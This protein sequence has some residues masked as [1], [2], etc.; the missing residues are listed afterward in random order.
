MTDRSRHILTLAVVALLLSGILLSVFVANKRAVDSADRRAIQVLNDSARE[1]TSTLTAALDGCFNALNSISIQLSESGDPFDPSIEKKLMQIDRD[2]ALEFTQIRILDSSGHAVSTD[3]ERASLDFS[4]RDYFKTAMSGKSYMQKAVGKLTGEKT[5]FLSVPVYKGS[6]VGGV[7]IGTFYEKEIRK[8]FSSEAYG[9]SGFSYVVESGGDIVIDSESRTKAHPLDNIFDSFDKQEMLKGY[10]IEQLKRDLKAG[11]STHIEFLSGGVE[12]IASFSPIDSPKLPVNDWFMVNAV[13]KDMLI[14]DVNA[15]RRDTLEAMLIFVVFAF[16]AL[17]LFFFLEREHRKKDSLAA[18]ELKRREEEYRIVAKQ[19]DKKVYRYNIKTE[20]AYRSEKEEDGFIWGT[21]VNDFVESNI[22]GGLVA[23]ESIGPYRDFHASVKAGKSPVTGDFLFKLANGEY[24]WFRLISTTIFDKDGN[25]DTAVVSYFDYTEQREREL[26]YAKWQQELKV[27]SDEDFSL[28]EWNLT[29]GGS[30]GYSGNAEFVSTHREN[31]LPFDAWVARYSNIRVFYDDIDDFNALMTREHLLGIYYNGIYQGSVEYRYV[32]DNASMCWHKMSIQMVPYPETDEIKIY[33]SDR[34]IDEEKNEELDLITRSESDSLTG[35]LNR[36]TFIERVQSVIQNSDDSGHALMML[37]LD[38]FKFVNDAMGHETG[39]EVLIEFVQRIN[40]VLRNDDFVGRVGG[41][42]F[43]VFIHNMPY[44]AAVGKKARDFCDVLRK[45]IGEGISVTVSIGIAMFPKDGNSFEELYNCADAAL[46]QAKG[47]GKDGYAFYE[48]GMTSGSVL[49]AFDSGANTDYSQ[50]RRNEVLLISDSEETIDSVKNALSEEYELHVVK[51]TVGLTE[52][53]GENNKLSITITDCDT[54]L[55]QNTARMMKDYGTEV[56]A[57]TKNY[58]SEALINYIE[59]GVAAVIPLPLNPELLRVSLVRYFMSMESTAERAQREYRRIQNS[60][61]LRYR[62]VLRATGTT[63]FVYD[64]ESKLYQKDQE[65]EQITDAVLDGY[66]LGETLM[67]GGFARE[68]DI[69]TIKDEL[70]NVIDGNVEVATSRLKIKTKSGSKRWFEVLIKKIENVQSLTP[71][72]LILVNDIDEQVKKDEE[73][74]AR[75]ERDELTGLY[76]R[77]TFFEKSAEMIE[78]R[79]PGYYMM[80][81]FDINN[82]KVIND[83]YGTAKGDDVLK[84]LAKVFTE[85]FDPLGGIVCRV[86]ADNFA[87]L[88]PKKYAE[89]SELEEIR[90]KARE[91]DGTIPPITYSIGRYTVTDKSMDVNAMYDRAAMA[92]NSVKGMYDVHTAE[93]DES[94][95]ERIVREQEIVNEMNDALKNGEFEPWIQPQYNHATGALVGGEILVRWNHPVRGVIM[96]LDFVPVFERNGFIYEM[97]KYIW[98]EACRLLRKWIDA[99]GDAMPLAVN[100]SR[101]DILKK[102][103]YETITDI[104]ERNNVP[105]ELFRL[106]I[107]ETAFSESAKEI[108]E[109]VDRLKAYG[110]IIEIDDFGSGYSSLNTL[111]DV[112]ANILK[113]DMRFIESSENTQRGGNI[114][115]SIIRMAKWLGMPVIAEGVETMEQAEFLKSIGCNYVQGYLY[116]RPMPATEYENLSAKIS[117]EHKMQALE[118]VENMDNNTFWDPKSMDTLIF[119]SYVGGACIIEYHRGKSETMRIN[120]KYVEA[121]GAENMSMDDVMKINWFDHA[122]EENKTILFDAITKAIET[123]SEAIFDVKL[124]GLPGNPCDIFLHSTIRVI[125]ST[126][127]RY[128]IYC[129]FDNITEQKETEQ[130]EQMVSAQLKAIMDNINGGVTAVVIEDGAPRYLFA[131]D[132]YFEQLGYTREQ[133][134]DE[135]PLSFDLIYEEDRE[136][137]INTTVKASKDRENYAVT[138]RVIRRDG[139]MGYIQS[140]ISITDFPGIDEPVQL[141]VANDITEQYRAEQAIIESS[142]Q[143]LFLNNISKE[144]LVEGDANT[145]IEFVLKRILDYFGG[146]RAA[147]IE[148]NK[149][150]GRDKNTYEVC[151]E[152]VESVRDELQDIPKEIFYHW[153][154]KL[155]KDKHMYFTTE[156]LGE[157]RKEERKF[158]ERLNITSEVAVPLLRDD[159]IIGFMG[160]ENPR[161]KRTHVDRMEAL[162]D[163]MAVLLTRR[164]LMSKIKRDSEIIRRLMDDTPGG[165]ARVQLKPGTDKYRIVYVNDNLCSML[166]YSRE[167]ML[168]LYGDTGEI[169]IHPDDRDRV[170]GFVQEIDARMGEPDATH[171]IRFRVVCKDGSAKEVILFARGTDAG[172]EGIFYNLYYA[173]ASEGDL[174]IHEMMPTMLSAM[175]ES[176]SELAFVKDTELNYICCTKPFAHMVGLKDEKE[177]AGKT[178]YDIFEKQLAENYIRDDKLVIKSG[179]SLVDIIERIPSEDGKIRYSQTSKHLLFNSLGEVIGLYGAGRDVTALVES[180]RMDKVLDI[181]INTGFEY[182]CVVHTEEGLYEICGNNVRNSH[183]VDKTGNFDKTVEMICREH[184]APEDREEYLQNAKLDAVVRGMKETNGNYSYRYVLDGIVR[185][186]RFYYYEDTHNEMVMTIKPL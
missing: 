31:E 154:S 30:D 68:E 138:Y 12:R 25:P 147:V 52:K 71:K 79:E 90:S 105:P 178:D 21:E 148:T 174:K 17:V 107:T 63:V 70:K 36:D 6:K 77:T 172:A 150:T 137:V 181:A 65:V 119:N 143:L 164:D 133:F 96:P 118:T 169:A 156:N 61:E 144:L 66:A 161:Q 163:Y 2:A 145:A 140:N 111:K 151:A 100:V 115:G 50:L 73:L 135:V 56:F 162:G 114:I 149:E 46:Y 113:L 186:V 89:S 165:F 76:N 153:H 182:I 177:I 117:K 142:E 83:Q 9:G 35:A 166:G 125:A 51:D 82:F 171:N 184:I 179:K 98:D 104:V 116:A 55:G 126:G 173:D 64:V 48:E 72:V 81:C 20:A 185:E 69:Q 44:E 75:A 134:E 58:G 112:P 168:S 19:N 53:L 176:S 101:Y 128:M 24:R 108:I 123:K 7:L 97:D 180:K 18:A 38:A 139:T 106:E 127:E 87:V 129:A 10:S 62:E 92:E 33:V 74:I 155:K 152:G 130:K 60:E 11:K 84:H 45:Q 183:G 80:A 37:D 93:Y 160:V 32:R 16:L 67:K 5:I 109:V 41:D 8:T 99:E 22:K 3:P 141:A 167:E 159:E 175:M 94:M 170:M 49:T 132:T 15:N 95:R 121:I 28:Y 39:D 136:R 23:D 86:M 146:D 40:S 120:D 14:S 131:N 59:L 29:T 158:L 157:D 122:D 57:L 1:Q 13:D 47:N 43:M 78:A 27:I 26:A 54:E 4:N 103:F 34:N 85:G 102:D 42:E 91:G 88:Y 110:F 124:S